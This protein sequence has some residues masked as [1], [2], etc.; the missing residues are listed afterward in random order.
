[1]REPQAKNMFSSAAEMRGDRDFMELLELWGKRGRITN[2][3]LERMLALFKRSFRGRT[4][5]FERI[6]ASGFLQLWL[7]GCGRSRPFENHP[8]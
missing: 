5:D 4:V 2:M 1:M 8:R 3:H 6:A 7:P